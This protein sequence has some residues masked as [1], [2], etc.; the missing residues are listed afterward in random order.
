MSKDKLQ[1]FSFEVNE[2][3]IIESKI[4]TIK[5]P[6]ELR[7]F[8]NSIKALKAK[9]F[10]YVFALKGIAKIV[11]N[12]S[13]DI[14]AVNS[15]HIDLLSKDKIWIYSTSKFELEGLKLHICEWIN[16]EL[17]KVGKLTNEFYLNEP[18]QWDYE[19]LSKDLFNDDYKLYDIIPYLYVN[20]MCKEQ[21]TFDS[22]NASFKFYPLISENEI[23]LISE[24]IQKYS[25]PFSYYIQLS[26][27]KPFDGNEKLYINL[28]LG[29]KIWRDTAL[30][31]DK[32]NF[33][34]GQEGTSVYIYKKDEFIKKQQI[35]FIQCLMIRKN[36]EEV[37]FKSS[38]DDIYS[39]HIDLNIN[40]VVRNPRNYMSFENNTICLITNSSKKTKTKRG[41]GEPERI[42]LFNIF[43]ERYSNLTPRVPV[44]GITYTRISK[45]TENKGYSKEILKSRNIEIKKW[46]KSP[47][48]SSGIDNI[49]KFVISVYSDNKNL[50]LD[51]I[52]ISKI[53]LGLR[54]EKGKLISEQEVEFEFKKA[55]EN[56]TRELLESESKIDR[57]YDIER[58]I[59]ST[60]ETFT[61]NL[62]LVDIPPFHNDRKRS[63][64]DSK[65]VVR[66]ALKNKGIITQFINGYK[67]E[68]S[69]YKL[70]N[71][72][73]DLYYAA[74][75]L[76]TEFYTKGFHKK[77]LLG[78]DFVQRCNRMLLV[79]SKL[80]NG[81]LYYKLYGDKKWSGDHELICKLDKEKILNAE[82]LLRD[83]KAIGVN[84]WI[85]DTIQEVIDNS[86]EEVYVYADTTLRNNYWK[87][88]MN[89]SYNIKNLKVID[90]DCKLKVI[91]INNTNE[92]PDYY[93]GD[94]SPN[95]N[96]GLFTNDY[97][98]FYMVGG[99]SD[100][101]KIGKTWTKYDS[102]TT[103]FVKQNVTEMIILGENKDARLEI[104]QE[105]FLLRRLV[106]T[107]D[108]ETLLPLPLY[109][110][111][112]I[113]EYVRA[114][115]EC[116]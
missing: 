48:K 89:H 41:V 39:G 11:R 9:N 20:D 66:V 78:I 44:Q 1:L 82:K 47:L 107:Y 49:N 81:R 43:R 40:D 58:E 8:I 64:L 103:P 27:K 32:Y 2:T 36:Q 95:Y 74:G 110:I 94:G 17:K 56:I 42:D 10:G 105:S 50:F 76:N 23:G 79:I 88:L 112:R 111:N 68:E 26:L 65:S 18:L 108:K 72:L 29:T 92:L 12:Y 3:N 52:A 97:E 28:T 86:K 70:Q 67:D 73:Y 4:Y 22:I 115:D 71:S 19:I 104:A 15:S 33:V 113:S 109:V 16:S 59:A 61:K 55:K 83:Q 24:P 98:T 63:H 106:P 54:E 37:K 53:I 6:K 45:T 114:I 101:F 30:V 35:S 90:D 38:Y 34:S 5:F 60:E 85:Y 57:V 13:R 96:K 69:Q 46:N 21:I 84:D 102:P 14:V 91:R 25:E 62:A 31:K 51:T 87:F 7:G 99:R 116:N 93:I 77:I 80:E 100:T 75:F